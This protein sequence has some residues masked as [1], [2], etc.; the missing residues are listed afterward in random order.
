VK[1]CPE[2]LPDDEEWS[3]SLYKDVKKDAERALAD[4]TSA[5]SATPEEEYDKLVELLSANSQHDVLKN[6]VKLGKEL[7]VETN[8]DETAWKLL[9]EFWSEMIL[10]VAPSDNLKAHKEVIALFR[11]GCASSFDFFLV[12][13]A[14]SFASLFV[15][16]GPAKEKKAG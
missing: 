3:K 13:C 4:H 7:V 16:S 6:G 9:A 15:L 1:R 11:I 12:K 5:S 8:N 14:S 2:L 10:Y